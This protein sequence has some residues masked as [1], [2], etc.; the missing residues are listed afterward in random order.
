MPRGAN[1]CCSISAGAFT[2]E[3]PTIRR[4]ISDSGAGGRAISRRPEISC[5]PAASR[6]TT[7]TGGAWICRMTGPSSC[8]SR[9][10]PRCTSKGFYPLGR[11]YPAT[12]VGWYRRVFELPADRRG[13]AHH[14]RVRWRLPRDDG[15]LQRLLHR[16][17]QRRI[18]SVQ[19][20]RDR[21]RQSRRQKCAAGARG[22]H[23]ERWLV[24]RGRGNLS[25]RLAG[26]DASGAR[27]AMGHLRALAR[28]GRTRR[29]FRSAR[30]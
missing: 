13:Q 12:S 18:R 1:G 14:D 4:R 22:C 8:P 25:A 5:L 20:R 3:M 19:L 23:V 6:S 10:I 11:T 27:E 28:C 16:P 21:L 15:G 2:S 7:A 26:E 30:K 9:T 29:R 17:P 24:L